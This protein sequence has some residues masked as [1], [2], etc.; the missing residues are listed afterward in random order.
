M[1]EEHTLSELT[2]KYGVHTNQISQWEKQAKEQIVA[3]FS[4]K[5]QKSQQRMKRT[6]RS[7]TPRSGSSLSKRIF[8]NKPSPKSEL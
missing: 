7:F 3:G 8:C 1:S 4:G 2:S 6:S 5:A